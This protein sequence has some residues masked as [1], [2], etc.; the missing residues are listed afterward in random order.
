[1]CR[2]CFESFFIVE[3]GCRSQCWYDGRYHCP[4]EARMVHRMWSHCTA[5]TNKE[6]KFMTAFITNTYLFLKK[7]NF[8]TSL[9]STSNRVVPTGFFSI[10]LSKIK[11]KPRKFKEF[12]LIF[13]NEKILS[14]VYDP[15]SAP[16]CETYLENDF[17]KNMIKKNINIIILCLVVCY[18][19]FHISVHMMCDVRIYIYCKFHH[20]SPRWDSNSR[21]YFGNPAP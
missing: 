15:R 14:N 19:S 10:K 11:F 13:I 17:L 16:P 2:V 6:K 18:L 5:P 3:T 7:L 9:T 8:H 20:H 12:S 4:F 21:F 1:M